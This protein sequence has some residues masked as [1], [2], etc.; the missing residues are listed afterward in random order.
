MT[1]VRCCR[2]ATLLELL[3]VIVLLAIS[4]PALFAWL[5]GSLRSAGL[6][7]ESV[8]VAQLGQQR[9]EILL[10]AKRDGRLDF[11]GQD[12]FQASCEDALTDFDEASGLTVPDGYSLGA[13]QCVLDDRRGTLTVSVAGPRNGRGYTVEVYDLE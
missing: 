13:P 6:E 10:A 7:G 11:S 5:N 8:R 2:G 12:A 4:V 3:A 1:S 9:I